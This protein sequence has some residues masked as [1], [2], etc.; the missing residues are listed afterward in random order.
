MLWLKF[1]FFH[2]FYP[3]IS[4]IEN[5]FNFISGTYKNTC[6]SRK[7]SETVPFTPALLNSKVVFTVFMKLPCLN[8]YTWLYLGL[9]KTEHDFFVNVKS[10]V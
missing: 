7:V 4:F 9:L 6:F 10:L 5:L 3:W 2:S 1:E 8:L